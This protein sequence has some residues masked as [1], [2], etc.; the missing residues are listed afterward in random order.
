MSFPKDVVRITK[1][2][3]P[4]Y[5][6][7]QPGFN[8]SNGCWLTGNWVTLPKDEW[9]SRK[10]EHKA[11]YGKLRELVKKQ[12]YRDP[13]VLPEQMDAA[14]KQAWVFNSGESI[15]NGRDESGATITFYVPLMGGK[16]SQDQIEQLRDKEIKIFDKVTTQTDDPES[17]GEALG[18]PEDLLILEPTDPWEGIVQQNQERMD[19]FSKM[20]AQMVMGTT[21]DP[22]VDAMAGG[23]PAGSAGQLSGVDLDDGG[24]SDGIMGLMAGVAM[25]GLLKIEEEIIR[26]EWEPNDKY[27]DPEGTKTRYVALRQDLKSQ[28]GD[29]FDSIYAQTKASNNSCAR[30]NLDNSDR[31]MFCFV[32]PEFYDDG[33]HEPWV[34]NDVPRRHSERETT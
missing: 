23:L 26:G 11:M 20:T 16:V 14:Q 21:G 8:E 2:R 6:L 12:H 17:I 32:L 33:T 25:T 9:D 7:Y 34:E 29:Q 13:A 5:Q 10:A 3:K 15:L 31:H 22:L 18:I 30:T 27:H 4:R 19:E 24:M 1:H 28:F